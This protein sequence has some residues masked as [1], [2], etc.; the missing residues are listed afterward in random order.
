MIAWDQCGREIKETII[1]DVQWVDPKFQATHLDDYTVK[2]KV[3]ER[4]PC[5]ECNYI[6]DFGDGSF[7]QGK[8]VI[9]TYLY[10]GRYRVT[11]GVQER[12]KDRRDKDIP[13]MRSNFKDATVD[14]S[15]Q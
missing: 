12:Q 13:E 3:A 11:L 7:G 6:W 2:F 15:G 8:Q 14:R 4:F 5:E 10:P 9:H 1:A